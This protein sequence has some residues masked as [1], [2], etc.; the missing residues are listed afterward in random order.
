VEAGQ[1]AFAIAEALEERALQVMTNFFLSLVYFIL[2]R[3]REAVEGFRRNVAILQGALVHERFAEPG[4]PA[5]F[6]RCFLAWSLAEL[7]A[8]A[9]GIATAEEAIRIADGIDEPFTLMHA[10]LGLG[11]ARLRKGDVDEAARILD[12]TLETCQRGDIPF[13]VPEITS[14]L[15]LACALA[16]RVADG[17]PF[18]E[19]A[20][21]QEPTR[22]VARGL[23]AAQLAEGYLLAGRLG[24][25][26]GAAQHAVELCREYKT[27]GSE[28]YALELV[29]AAIARQDSPDLELSEGP[30]REALALAD[31]LGMRPLVAH[32]H[33]GLGTLYRR[34]RERTSAKEHLTTATA[35]YREMNMPYW[36]GQAEAEL[37]RLA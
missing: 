8:F 27:R 3:H 25:A 9:E 16:G 7:G 33:L 21:A 37:T 28:A 4:L 15:G 18:L 24:D 36:L 23:I 35:M 17:L 14:G 22:Q 13:W 20:A 6:S 5:V 34:T 12:R 29:G 31:E 10:Y 2:G 30:Y 32:C 26:A 19:Q 1:R 11:M